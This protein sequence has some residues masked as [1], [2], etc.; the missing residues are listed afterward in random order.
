MGLRDRYR[1]GVARQL[2]RPEGLRGRMVART[3]N[4]VNRSVVTGAIDAAALQP[5]QTAADL[6]FGGGVGL[7]MML[8]RVGPTGHVQGVELS[9]TMLA[10][11]QQVHR[12]A[13]AAGRMT[14]QQGSLAA[15]PLADTSVDGL[16]SVNT[17]YFVDDLEP[18]Y[19]ELARVLR[20]S[21][22]AVIGVGDPAAMA[23]MPFT[24]HGFRLR[25]V[26][27]IEASLRAAGFDV[28]DERIGG[29]SDAFHLL[30]GTR[31]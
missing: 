26:E 20:P 4:R 28:H 29:G 8:D 27:Q 24:E 15:L 5:G 16:I 2:G 11:A 13:I 21:G 10:K 6:G 19:R 9:S 30:V 1:A 7:A 31:S 12:T 25:P 22:R 23:R 17:L 3:L 18:V 14:V